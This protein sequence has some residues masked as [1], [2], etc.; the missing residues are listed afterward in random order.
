M[1]TALAINP[2]SI[3]RRYA[4]ARY[5]RRQ[6][7][8]KLKASLG[9]L[10]GW[11]TDPA[12]QSEVAMLLQLSSDTV[13]R[14]RYDTMR[15]EYLSPNVEDL[16]GFTA[17]ELMKQPLRSLILETRL[18]LDSMKAVSKYEG[19]ELARQNRDVGKWQA[20]YLIQRADGRRIWVSDV[21]YP[22]RNEKGEVIGSIGTLRDITDRVEA[23]AAAVEYMEHLLTTDSLTGLGTRAVFFNKLEEEAR[24]IKRTDSNL[25]VVLLDVDS[26][27]RINTQYGREF[28]DYVL[29]EISKLIK[30]CLRGTDIAARLGGEE[31]GIILPDTTADGTYWVAE[32]IRTTIAGHQFISGMGRHPLQCTVSI[33]LSS[34]NL[35]EEAEP[36]GFFRRADMRLYYAKHTGHNRVCTYTDTGVN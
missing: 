11:R 26:F 6:A 12:L 23:T 18:V 28:G 32:R 1:N 21:S 35:D 4:L 14:L 34:T 10:S 30:S 13:Y 7:K 36:M 25:S 17:N 22:W 19:L 29:Q 20:D 3:S 16:L 31:F 15:Y 24:R 8:K 27:K 9:W 5:L 33:G 2:S